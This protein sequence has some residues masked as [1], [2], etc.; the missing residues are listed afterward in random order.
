MDRDSGIYQRPLLIEYKGIR[1]TN[2]KFCVTMEVSENKKVKGY[3]GRYNTKF[4]GLLMD[5]NDKIILSGEFDQTLEAEQF[6]DVLYIMDLEEKN[7]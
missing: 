6:V 2:F 3:H 7:E 4:T 5:A 1:Y